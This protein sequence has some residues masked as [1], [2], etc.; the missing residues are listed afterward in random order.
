VSDNPR[1]PLPATRDHRLRDG[2]GR[3]LVEDLG[4][5]VDD[6]R[7]MLVEFGLRPYTVHVVRVRWSGGE[8]GRGTPAT[9][10]DLALLPTPR[11]R[12]LEALAWQSREGGHVER[13]DV[14]LEGIS[15]RYTEDEIESY[16]GRAD[17]EECF[18]EVRM[19]R[20]DG[21]EPERR[22]FTIASP[23]VRR[24]DRFDWSVTIRKQDGNRERDGSRR[25]PRRRVW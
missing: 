19:D 18:V 16:F 7:Q 6:L 14:R 24:P 13:G 3:S 11:V 25:A 10:V 12:S 1:G 23:P 8:V 20:R 5:V 21:R 22:R 4:G 2:S 17:G 15:P 9:A